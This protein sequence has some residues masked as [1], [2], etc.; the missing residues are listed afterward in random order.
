MQAVE[1]GVGHRCRQRE[2]RQPGGV[3]DLV[4]IGVAD[5]AEHARIGERALEG[6][7]LPAQHRTKRVECDGE[8]LDTAA[9][10]RGER[11]LAAHE[12]Q[13]ST[14]RGAGLGEDHGPGREIERRQADPARHRSAAR[15]P[16]QPAR[17]HQVEGQEQ[18][19]LEREHEPLPDPAQ[20]R[21]APA[22]RRGQGGLDGAHQKRGRDPDLL[23]ELATDPGL[24]RAEVEL[25][26][27][28]LGHP[29]KLRGRTPEAARCP[30]GRGIPPWSRSSLPGVSCMVSPTVVVSA[31]LV[32]AGLVACSGGTA[33]RQDQAP[34]P[35]PPPGT[36]VRV[37]TIRVSVPDPEA[38]RRVAELEMRLLERDAQIERLE[39][40]LDDTRREVVR[41]LAR[42]QTT[43]SRAEA[44]SALAEADIAIQTLRSRD[45]Q[46]PELGFARRLLDES[47]AEFGKQNYGG[48]LYLA[49]QVKVVASAGRGRLGDAAG[50]A[51]PG[52]TAF[53]V[54]VP[55]RATARANVREGPG[56]NFRVSFT[57]DAGVALTGVSR[58][59][60]WV[61]VRD[62]AG[63]SGWVYYNLVGRRTD[64]GT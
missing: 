61:R 32:L 21:H 28:Q 62:G 52:E 46:A 44:A 16:A 42:L 56:T 17:D 27:R 26:V 58:V 18:V 60:E 45:A 59:P 37:D 24:E 36:P 2:R 64:G 12:V 54:P 22:G 38:Q 47:T 14:P 57:V 43:A 51:R 10:E 50:G 48:A 53:A 19:R 30:P 49:N 55:L 41:S 29:I 8:G 40:S 13:C 9:V 33:A 63:R 23:E 15:P 7:V 5:A 11:H 25:D 6:V 34:A 35:G 4:G 31:V 39:A 20:G 3:Q 1:L